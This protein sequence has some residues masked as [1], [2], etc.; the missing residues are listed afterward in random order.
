MQKYRWL[1]DYSRTVKNQ[2]E[3]IASLRKQ[4]LALDGDN[5]EEAKARRQTLQDKLKNAEEEL[6][7]TEYEQ[8]LQDAERLWSS[9]LEQLQEYF[10]KRIDQINE[11]LQD[12]IDFG[13][14]NSELIADTL[15]ST[16]DKVG[17]DLSQGLEQT[18]R[19]TS[20]DLKAVLTGVDTDFADWKSTFS[21]TMTTT[22]NY[23]QGI[24][25]IL[26]KATKSTVVVDN[27]HGVTTEEDLKPKPAPTP[28]PAPAAPAKT[29]T[30]SGSSSSSTPKVVQVGSKVRVA[31]SEPIYYDSYGTVGPNGSVQ[32]FRNDPVYYVMGENNGYWLLRHHTE[33]TAAG[34]FRKSAVTA[35]KTGG[36]TGNQDGYALLHKKERVL[37]AAQTKAFENLIYNQLPEL[38]NLKLDTKSYLSGQASNI[39]NNIQMEF[40]LPN[41]TDVQSFMKELQN[42]KQFEKLIQ[43]MTIDQLNN[44][45]S[46]RKKTIKF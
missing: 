25:Q 20:A 24:F 11:L 27:V 15:V 8:Y 35:M 36:Y 17:Y 7:A 44:K 1:Y 28:A 30:S 46:L 32:Y 5:S 18:W 3:G 10:D 6:E 42:N 43:A 40:N 34:W 45:N 22:N 2:V 21:G 37:S 16:S 39:A 29:P 19:N 23:I 14:E 41:V 4:L 33:S 12:M 38:M 31:A 13:N 9:L 26:K